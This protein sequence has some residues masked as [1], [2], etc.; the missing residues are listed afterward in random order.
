MTFPLRDDW[1][2]GNSTDPEAEFQRRLVGYTVSA[3]AITG[4][5]AAGAG[6]AQA[7][8]IAD[9]LAT[10]LTIHADFPASTILFDFQNMSAAVGGTV[11][12][13]ESD[14]GE[15]ELFARGV[16]D[17]YDDLVRIGGVSNEIMTAAGG[18]DSQVR[19]LPKSYLIPQGDETP[20]TASGA[21]LY[22]TARGFA[23]GGSFPPYATDPDRGYIGMTFHFGADTADRY[24]GWA[25]VSVNPDR[26]VTLYGFGYD[27][28]PGQPVPAG[29]IGS[30]APEPGAL[31]L[32]LIGGAAAMA[33]YRAGK[34][35]RGSA[36]RA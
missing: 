32:L 2:A 33:A 26:S 22:F 5:F 15:F 18:F 35:R 8:Y 7:Q 34:Y 21:L 17:I 16:N 30:A 3:V 13:V 1:L 9:D 12:G 23:R 28:V 29:K 19:K 6:P 11:T 24:N 31:E 10:P 20:G 36:A 25:D 14:N 27:D 4:A